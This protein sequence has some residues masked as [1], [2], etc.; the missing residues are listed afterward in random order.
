MQLQEQLAKS[1]L[2]ERSRPYVDFDHS[3]GEA[4][5]IPVRFFWS[6][7]IRLAVDWTSAG[8]SALR[9]RT[10]SYFSP[11]FH[12]GETGHPSAL[13]EVGSIGSLVN[14]PAF[15][16]IEKLSAASAASTKTKNGATMEK[17]MNALVEAKLIPSTKLDDAEAAGLVA[18]ALKANAETI[19]AKDQRIVELEGKIQA[20]QQA[21]AETL[22]ASAVRAGK[23]KDE[24]A[25][26]GHWVSAILKDKVAASAMLE[27]IEAKAKAAKPLDADGEGDTQE[28]EATKL[29]ASLTKE[30][31][32]AKR[33]AICAKLK[34][35]RDASAN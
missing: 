29:R 7:G 4:A 3:G 13:P 19:A 16:S 10:Y 26:R 22:V 20:A 1:A 33:G 2:G 24:P 17:L 23:V 12:I 28:D 27:G 11:E 18:A 9:G 32:P 31:D 15:Q 5:A 25:I 34:K 6:D 14:T 35:M 30:T 21:E 8:A